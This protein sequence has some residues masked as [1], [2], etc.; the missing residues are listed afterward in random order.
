MKKTCIFVLAFLLSLSICG[1]N[2]TKKYTELNNN[3]LNM[4]FHDWHVWSQEHTHEIMSDSLSVWYN[5]ISEYVAR[6]YKEEKNTETKRLMTKLASVRNGKYEHSMAVEDSINNALMCWK[7]ENAP[8]GYLCC[9]DSVAIFVYKTAICQTDDTPSTY[10]SKNYRVFAPKTFRKV[11]FLTKEVR[12][13][14]ET[15]CG[16]LSQFDPKTGSYLPYTPIN[17][18]GIEMLRKKIPVDHKGTGWSFLS[19]PY[20]Y[21]IDLYP[22]MRRVYVSKTAD[23]TYEL[24]MPYGKIHRNDMLKSAETIWD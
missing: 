23:T 24:S 10:E 12:R 14:L 18:K 20:V 16:G 4:F 8:T 19:R 11:L 3:N 7:K 2:F 6:E 13:L 22:N 5:A 9:P 1:Q 21:R 17:I 15:F